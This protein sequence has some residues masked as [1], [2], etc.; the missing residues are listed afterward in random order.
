MHLAK[1]LCHNVRMHC[2]HASACCLFLF[3]VSGCHTLPSLSIHWQ[4]SCEYIKT[5]EGDTLWAFPV[6]TNVK[7]NRRVYFNNESHDPGAHSPCVSCTDKKKGARPHQALFKDLLTPKTKER[8]K[9]DGSTLTD[10]TTS[11]Q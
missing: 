5:T 6:N 7:V 4:L 10:S 8:K 3:P 11:E 2:T 1:R 9:K